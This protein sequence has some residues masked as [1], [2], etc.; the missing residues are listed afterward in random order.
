MNKKYRLLLFTILLQVNLFGQWKK[1]DLPDTTFFQQFGVSDLVKC[2]GSL[3]AHEDHLFISSNE[4]ESWNHLPFAKAV[5]HLYSTGKI[6]FLST[7]DGQLFRSLDNGNTWINIDTTFLIYKSLPSPNDVYMIAGVNSL[8]FDS[9][10]IFIGTDAGIFRSQNSGINWT[11]FSNGLPNDYDNLHFTGITSLL[12]NGS[13]IFAGTKDN[14]IYIST[15]KG[16]NWESIN[17]GLPKVPTISALLYNRRS[18]FALAGGMIYRLNGNN[19]WE[20]TQ[21][22][23][24]ANGVFSIAYKDSLLFALTLDALYCSNDNGNNWNEIYA[25]SLFNS[26]SLVGIKMF[27]SGFYLFGVDFGIYFSSNNGATWNSRN[28]GLGEIRIRYPLQ[29][30]VY[31]SILGILTNDNKTFLSWDNGDSWENITL[32]DMNISNYLDNDTIFFNL[33]NNLY[34]KKEITWYR[35]Y[36]SYSLDNVILLDMTLMRIGSTPEAEIYRGSLNNY[37]IINNEFVPYWEQCL[38]GSS[39]YYS[40]A[41]SG[42][43]TYVAASDGIYLSRDLG[44]SWNQ[45][46]LKNKKVNNLVLKNTN[47]IVQTND[48]FYKSLDEGYNWST[49]NLLLENI[50]NLELCGDNLIALTASPNNKIWKR[51]F[52]EIITGLKEKEVSPTKFL[53]SQNYPNPFNPSTKIEYS[54]SKDIIRNSESL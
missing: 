1:I 19:A 35:M 38:K 53:L 21:N 40:L 42:N 7:Y 2:N 30:D 11:S 32:S 47:L 18:V 10:A 54:H 31:N 15:D 39:A 3:I 14:G 33:F 24:Q 6:L 52:N 45:I 8:D 34:V 9:T 37:Q 25:G 51:S 27:D 17:D 16:N 49:V 26:G 41:A 22:G 46:G 36:T 12:I 4:G 5:Y 28:D 43:N 44:V 23:V 29:I 13:K 50:V 48:G 20:K